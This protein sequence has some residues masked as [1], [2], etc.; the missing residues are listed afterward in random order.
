[1]PFGL[2]GKETNKNNKTTKILLFIRR[3]DYVNNM[4][5][6]TCFSI[7]NSGNI[8]DNQDHL[9]VCLFLA[10]LA[11]LGIVW[12]DRLEMEVLT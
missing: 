5:I 3:E 8:F 12:C 6:Q 10:F 7:K 9:V 11:L 1:M 2:R 4:V